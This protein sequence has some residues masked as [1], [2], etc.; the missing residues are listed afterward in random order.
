[1]FKY[2]ISEMYLNYFNDINCKTIDEIENLM[3]KC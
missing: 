3:M 1:M 2:F